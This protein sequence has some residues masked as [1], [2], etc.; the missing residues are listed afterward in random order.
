MNERVQ[1]EVKD[2]IA[3]VRLCR[4]ENRNAL[5]QP[6]FEGLIQAGRDLSADPSVR[7]AVL[8][9]EGPAFCSGLYFMSFASMMSGELTSDSEQVK[10]AVDDKTEGGASWFQLPAWT[11]YEAPFPVIA[12][13]QGAA[14][15]AGLHIALGADMRV[16]APDAKLAFVEVNWGLVPDMSASQSLRRLVPLDVAKRM[17]M[18]GLPITGTQA[19]RYG[20][21]TELSDTPYVRARELAEIISKKSPDAIRSIKRLLNQSALLPLA[22]GLAMEFE[23]SGALMGTPNQ[24]EAIGSSFEKREPVFRDPEA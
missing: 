7:V 9:G 19:E 15:G 1:V 8:H 4:P 16:V 14:Y 17:A 20:L 6:M 11:L 3:E 21:A 18:T 12:A 2:G 22:E 23:C 5:D 24:M 10:K 13:V